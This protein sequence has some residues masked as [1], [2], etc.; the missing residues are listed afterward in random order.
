MKKLFVILALLLSLTWV[1]QAEKVTRERA[2]EMALTF[3]RSAQSAGISPASVPSFKMVM[4]SSA[5]SDALSSE[6]PAFYVFNN[7]SGPGF[8]IISA[9]DAVKPVLGYSFE[10]NF[11]EGRTLPPNLSAWLEG[12]AKGII[13]VRKSGTEPA[14]VAREAWKSAGPGTPVKE[15][16]TAE[17][18]QDDPYNRL[19][20]EIYGMLS[21]TGCVAT[22]LAIV[23]RYHEWPERGTGTLPGYRTA[24]FGQWVDGI[25]LGHAYDWD[26]MPLQYYNER[27]VPVFNDTEAEAVAVLMRD[28]G[29]LMKSDY[30][31]YGTGA[32]TDD[33]LEPL[34]ENMG[35][36]P[37]LQYIFKN[38]YGHDEWV[39]LMKNEID[40]DRPIIYGGYAAD[41]SGGHSFVLDGYDSEDFFSVN[42]GWGGSSDGYFDIDILDPY[43]QGIGGA[44]SGFSVG[45]D[46]IIG[47][48]PYR[49]EPEPSDEKVAYVGFEG[50]DENEAPYTY[51]GLSVK[52][53]E[54]AQNTPFMLYAGMVS[55]LGDAAIDGFEVM[56]AVTDMGGKTVEVLS[57][58][59][60][61]DPFVPQSGLTYCNEVTVTQPIQDGYRIRGYF[62]SAATPEWTLIRNNPGS[63]C[64]WEL[65]LE[66]YAP[67]GDP[68]DEN[69]SVTY[70]KLD[71]K[72]TV[73]TL[74][75]ADVT[76]A[77]VN[78]KVLTVVRAESGNAS[79][80]LSEY[81]ED[82][83]TLRVAKGRQS[84]EV[85]LEF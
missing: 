68:L 66:D 4:S 19:C 51:N 76:L 55:N 20:P 59:M 53:E 27:G 14:A 65:M 12:T 29:V 57:M 23:M 46:A 44:N 83:Y 48:K 73:G 24:S 77:D 34:V 40:N 60:E 49:T 10:N 75:G 26:N 74:A 38:R 63:G 69:T 85:K 7:T 5:V 78:G 37:S 56:F 82:I 54:I 16:E 50:V 71:N 9:D 81:G 18:N 13:A 42:W 31:W 52:V 84:I 28:C 21:V 35:Y 39:S 25:E 58:D 11:P 43:Q 22:S 45:Q 2:E 70:N 3:F 79:F 6:E 33:I 17:W 32:M 47:I 36:D 67:L 30:T 8:I 64:V 1:A 62:R 41:G 80:D 61:T 15:L 72:L